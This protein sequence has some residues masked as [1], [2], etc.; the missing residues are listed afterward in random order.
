[1]IK[2]GWLL[3]L[4]L[5]S[6]AAV[7]FAAA[8]S[9]DRNQAM[10]A[11]FVGA[12]SR[13]LA[14]NVELRPYNYSRQELEVLFAGVRADI[15]P[16]AK[17]HVTHN[18]SAKKIEIYRRIF[19]NKDAVQMGRAYGHLYAD[20]L[21]AAEQR[22]G[23]PQEIIIAIIC[24]ESGF[25]RN[26]GNADAMTALYTTYANSVVSEKL[27]RAREFVKQTAYFLAL[28]K[29]E[30]WDPKKVLGSSAGALGIPQ[31]M[32]VA[33]WHYAADGD[34]DGRIN[35]FASHPDAIFSA[36]NYLF[37]HG[38]K[39]DHRGSILK[40]NYDSAYAETILAYA[41]ALRK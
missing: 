2:R 13:E 36:A 41:E 34:G 38:W 6:A 7:S 18:G 5:I 28:C 16:A 9:S 30:R 11:E 31:F 17:K 19:L 27:V 33:W 14:F 24:L 35:L 20:K 21:R 26:L 1:M 8:R 3:L 12:V 39:Q 25:G 4:L 37:V 22:Y 29:K 23:V 32:S 10:R 40:Y 15:K